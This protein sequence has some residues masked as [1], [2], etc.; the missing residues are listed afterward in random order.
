MLACV[1]EIFVITMCSFETL[2]IHYV[3][4]HEPNMILNY[5]QMRRIQARK[6]HYARNINTNVNFMLEHDISS[7]SKT[8]SGAAWTPICCDSVHVCMYFRLL[9]TRAR[10]HARMYTTI[11]TY[12]RQC[13]EGDNCILYLQKE[14]YH[15]G[16]WKASCI[17]N[18]HKASLAIRI[19]ICSIFLDKLY[20]L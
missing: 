14:L 4:T 19:C 1:Q 9:H 8:H 7:P 16:E 11:H 15:N 3:S 2:W 20:Q 17:Q 6:T 10:T 12:T 18:S 13:F 5:A